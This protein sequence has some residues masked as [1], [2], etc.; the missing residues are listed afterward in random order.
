MLKVINKLLDRT[1]KDKMLILEAIIGMSKIF[2]IM[3]S[4]INE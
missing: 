1:A 2:G 3:R 4:R